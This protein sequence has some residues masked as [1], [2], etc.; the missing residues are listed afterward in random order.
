M[1]I[2]VPVILLWFALFS[3]PSIAVGDP[4]VLLGE[5]NVYAIY[6]DVGSI[7]LVSDTS[8]KSWLKVV[9]KVQELK[10]DILQSRKEQRL[11]VKCYENFAY[12]MESTEVECA[13]EKHRILETSD[14]D[15]TDQKIGASFPVSEWKQTQPDTP[16][17]SLAKAICKEHSK[18]G[19]WWCDYSDHKSH[20]EE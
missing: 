19:Y 16:Y 8:S 6:I 14:Y 15:G 10:E 17:N 12:R 20:K 1:N 5:D 11:E 9:P 2:K 3:W 18:E 4:W 7:T 13:L